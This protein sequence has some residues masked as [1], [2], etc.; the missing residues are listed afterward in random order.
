MP[1]GYGEQSK[2]LKLKKALYGLRRSPLL[3]QQKLTDQIKKLGFEATS[4]EPFLVQKTAIFYFFYM[5]NI[6]FAFK[7]DQCDEVERT[8]ASLSKS[9]TIE[10][11]EELKWFLG[12][13][14]I[15]D[16]SKRALLLSQKAYILKI[17][18]DLAPSTSP[19]RLPSTPMEILE[20][21]AVLDNEDITDA[22]RTLYPQKV[23]SLLFAANA[24]RPDI[25]FAV[26]RFSQFNQ[27][28]GKRHH[29]AADRVFIICFKQKIIAFAIGETYKTYHH[30]YTLA[31]LLSGII[32]WIE[33]VPK[34]VS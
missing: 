7:K 28:P 22:W 33:K 5:D 17:C 21:L 2:V 11:K 1:P 14:M 25:A 34:A 31:I 23:G 30:L 19:S 26:S 29:E 8:V 18:N 12:L 10:R 32:H 9:L 15:H 3:L 16:C 6:V 27:L 20:L 13:H 4:Q 24:T